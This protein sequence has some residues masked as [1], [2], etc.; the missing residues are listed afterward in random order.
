MTN[1]TL[2]MKLLAIRIGP[3]AVILPK[4]VK[5]INLEFAKHI[6]GG[7]RGARKFWRDILPRLKYRNP[8]IPMTVSRHDTAEGP[9][10]MTVTFTTPTPAA[11]SSTDATPVELEARPPLKIDM[12][13]RVES[14]ILQELIKATGGTEVAPTE[15]ELEE[16]RELEEEAEKS[17]R[18]RE[19]SLAVRRERK[20]EEEMLKAARGVA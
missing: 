13:N 8:A 17:A 18:D 1:K 10:V 6:E 2:R 19:R 15:V 20:R 3:G 11:G 5:K 4:D 12:R 7:H 14:E 16:K 9:S